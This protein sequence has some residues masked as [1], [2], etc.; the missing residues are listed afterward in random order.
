MW[1]YGMAILGQCGGT[2]F[3]RFRLPGWIALAVGLSLGMV[4]IV[5]G[6]V[7]API[8]PLVYLL[9]L[10]LDVA[11]GTALVWSIVYWLVLFGLGFGL[12]WAVDRGRALK[13]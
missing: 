9:W 4:L 6:G 5:L 1:V 13:A 2:V 11:P 3:R 7:F 12:G 8:N 10:I